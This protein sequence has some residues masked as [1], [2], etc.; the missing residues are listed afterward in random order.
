[1]I[2]VTVLE[3]WSTSTLVQCSFSRTVNNTARGTEIIALMVQL[4]LE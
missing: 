4:Y 2:P 3:C 1:M